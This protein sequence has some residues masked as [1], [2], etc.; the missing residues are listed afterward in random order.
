MVRKYGLGPKGTNV[1]RDTI[2]V[3]TTPTESDEAK[4]KRLQIEVMKAK[5]TGMSNLDWSKFKNNIIE[6]TNLRELRLNNIPSGVVDHLKLE[7][8][9]IRILLNM[10]VKWLNETT[11]EEE[12]IHFDYK[13]LVVRIDDET[14]LA[15]S[16][17]PIEIIIMSRI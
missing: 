10:Y 16:E 2:G 6:W 17:F 8:S 11:P 13:Y 9:E 15:I 5:F 3:T 1:F 14:A 12:E 7:P 4:I